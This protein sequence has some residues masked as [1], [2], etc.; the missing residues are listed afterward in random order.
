MTTFF[1]TF[2]LSV[3]YMFIDLVYFSPLP[4]NDADHVWRGVA[5]LAIF[6][7]GIV[8]AVL[9]SAAMAVLKVFWRHL[10]PRLRTTRW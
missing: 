8:L 4:Q 6:V 5:P 9:A 3:L 1:A 10:K 7:S 2:S